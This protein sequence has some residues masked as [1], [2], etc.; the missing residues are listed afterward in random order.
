MIFKLSMGRGNRASYSK[1]Q[2]WGR[3]ARL[4]GSNCITS[5]FTCS[6][7]S[8]SHSLFLASQE[9]KDRNKSPEKR[10]QCGQGLGLVRQPTGR[11]RDSWH[12]LLLLQSL[13]TCLRTVFS[14]LPSNCF[15]Q[16]CNLQLL[17]PSSVIWAG[18]HS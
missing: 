2:G 5:S 13:W 1:R 8:E 9:T 15:P 10:Q 11:G 18:D 3:R 6:L 4:D 17:D 12:L 7:T 16:P 14:P